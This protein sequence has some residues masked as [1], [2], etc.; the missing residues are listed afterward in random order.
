MESTLN[1]IT[2]INVIFLQ[3]I[4]RATQSFNGCNGQLLVILY[5]MTLEPVDN[6]GFKLRLHLLIRAQSKEADMC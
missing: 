1:I 4:N 6:N 5:H 3:L 2:T